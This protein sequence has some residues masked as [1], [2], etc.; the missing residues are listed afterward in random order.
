MRIISTENTSGDR[1]ITATKRV[2]ET[3]GL[4]VFPSDTV[5]GL[6]VDATNEKAVQKL[7][8]F[9]ERPVGKAVSIFVSDFEMMQE[10]VSLSEQQERLIHELLP[11]PFTIV[12]PSKHEVSHL[13]ESERGSLGVRIPAYTL[14]N[15]LMK[16][17]SKPVTATSANLSG[18]SPH[19]SPESLLNV[20]PASKKQ[21]IDLIVNTGQLSRNKPSTV[22]D[23]TTG[24]VQIIRKGDIVFSDVQ[25]FLSE[26]PG[27]TKKIAAHIMRNIESRYLGKSIS[28]IL[29]GELGVG[30]TVFAK[31]IGSYYDVEEIVSPTYVICNEYVLKKQPYEYLYHLDLYSI[32]D[33][34]EFKH[35]GV[36]QMIGKK[37]INVIEWGEK[38]GLLLPLLQEK[39]Q[40]VYIAI[41]YMN[42]TDREIQVKKQA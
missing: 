27:Q 4:V 29:M 22:V 17:F 16:V 9:K 3:G 19:Y 14:I 26:S 7:I 5:Y 20:L 10:Y 35:L 6:L 11:G 32:E 30:K 15:Q 8:A 23:L 24:N 34:E 37:S 25:R 28:L 42:Q 33:E 36:A 31:G 41:S 18:E 1:I 39:T 13:L 12:L 2:L 38:I 21:L 40:V